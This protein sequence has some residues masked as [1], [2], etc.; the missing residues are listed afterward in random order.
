MLQLID[1]LVVLNFGR[2]AGD[3][4]PRE[5]LAS[6]SVIESYLGKPLE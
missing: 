6:P 5:V 3:G 2:M 1:R 4:Q